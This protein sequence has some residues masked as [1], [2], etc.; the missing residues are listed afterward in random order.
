MGRYGCI[1]VGFTTKFIKCSCGIPCL[2][3]PEV[4]PRSDLCGGLGD[5]VVYADGTFEERSVCIMDSRD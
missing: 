3:A 2:H 4:H 1:S 5:L